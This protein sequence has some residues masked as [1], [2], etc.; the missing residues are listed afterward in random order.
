MPCGRFSSPGERPKICCGGSIYRQHLRPQR[1]ARKEG[2]PG[3]PI[4]P[5]LRLPRSL[6]SLLENLACFRSDSRW[7]LM[8]RLAWRTLFENDRL[9]ADPA[10][11]DVSHATSMERAVRRDIHKMHAFV[12]FREVTRLDA[13]PS[14]FAWFEPQHE[15]LQ[16]GAPFFLKRFPNMEWTI[17]TP[18]GAAIWDRSALRFVDSAALG[19]RPLADAKEDLWRTYYRSICNVSRVNPSAMQREMPQLYWRNLPEAAEIGALLREGNARFAAR[20]EQGDHEHFSA[21]KSLQRSLAQVATP[22]EGLQSCRACDLWKH[23]TQAVDGEGPRSAKLM[24]VG[25]QPGDEEDFARSAVR[26]SRG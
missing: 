20:H 8:Y 23:A 6:M 4:E 13:E 3:Q 1:Q 24:L 22:A 11:A 2:S 5:E 21:A 19:E 12:R 26:R 25:E 9:L 17:A 7:E 15:I 18:D 10:D 16:K 14:Y